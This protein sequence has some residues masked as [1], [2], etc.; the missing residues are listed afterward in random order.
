MPADVDEDAIKVTVVLHP[1]FP[2]AITL[3]FGIVVFPITAHVT[4]NGHPVSRST[5]VNVYVPDCVIGVGF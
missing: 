1:K 4:D 2:E 3:K 5:T